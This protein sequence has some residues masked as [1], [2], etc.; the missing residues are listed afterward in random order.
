MLNVKEKY[1]AMLIEIFEAYCPSAEIWAYGSRVNGDSHSG[2]DLDLV[3]K[4]FNDESKSIA[5][6][7]ELLT[8]SDIPFLTDINEFDRLPAAFQ[9]EIMKGYVV[10]FPC[11]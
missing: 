7:R 11:G 3:V 2:S 4:S 1:L 5:T 10:V 6:L 9:E 8:D